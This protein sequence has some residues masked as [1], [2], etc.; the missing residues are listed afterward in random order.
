VTEPIRIVDRPSTR[1]FY[2][3]YA[4]GDD[5]EIA[6]QFQAKYGQ[7]PA[8]IVRNPSAGSIVL[9]GPVLKNHIEEMRKPHPRQHEVDRQSAELLRERR[10]GAG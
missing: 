2:Q 6:A 10:N 7:P 9:A 4:S 1:L 3:G 5:A 8:E